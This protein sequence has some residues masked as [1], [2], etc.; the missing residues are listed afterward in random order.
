MPQKILATRPATGNDF[1]YVWSVYSGAVKQHIAPKLKDGWHD[2]VEVEKFRKMWKPIDSH[3]ITVDENPIG[4]GGVVTSG[5]EVW[6]EHLYIEPSHRGKGYGTRLVSELTKQWNQE[7]KTVHAPVLK[8][9]R[10]KKLVSRLGFERSGEDSAHALTQTFTY[11][12]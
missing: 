10:L 4:W 6:I 2:S 11:K 5:N 12:K 9:E 1:Q 7:G 8:D 3:I